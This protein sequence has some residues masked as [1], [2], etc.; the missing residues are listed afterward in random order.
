MIFEQLV[1]YVLPPLLGAF[2]GYLTN[3]IAIRMLFRPL[4]PWRIAGLRLPMT[5]GII[6]AKRHELA[7]K[8]GDMVGG[9]LFTAADV[10]HALAKESFR[11]ELKGVVADKLSEFLDRELGP[12]ESLIPI[13]YRGR[14]REICDLLR[15]KL[16]KGVFHYLDSAE[17]EKSLR[18]YLRRRGDE[19]LA[20]DLE[21]YLTPARYDKWR[22]HADDRIAGF[23]RSDGVARG[24]AAFVDNRAEQWLGSGKTLREILPADMVEILLAQL[25]KEIPPL[26]EKFGGMLY[27]PDFRERL[28]KKGREG[29]DHFLDSLGGLSGLLAGF[30]NLDKVYDRIPEFL[31]KA[32]DEIAR[33]LREEKTQ[34]Q[35][36]V[37]LRER[38]DG[39]LDRTLGSYLEK[40]PYEKVAGVRRF[41]RHRAVEMVRSRRAAD[42]VM[43]LAEQGVA[44]L[45]D[46]SFGSLLARAVP[47]GGIDQARENLANRLLAALRSPE[48]KEALEHIVAEKMDEW[49]YQHPLGKLSARI[50]G[51]AREELEEGI[52]LQLE[53]ILK[54]EVPPL[55]ETLNVRRMVEDKVNSLDILK[56]EGLLMGIMKEQFKYINLFGA[57]LGFLIGLTNLLVLSLR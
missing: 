46:R 38:I 41:V 1:P 16:V 8:M 25:E 43:G 49:L 13:A 3:Y 30:I 50:P 18:D 17:F 2:I 11:R 53:E 23:L 33:W 37:L 6:P 40:V 31:D 55:V 51:D 10:G 56:V 34:Q 35:V 27:D 29:I 12:V 15:W 28:V 54:K 4:L 57:L 32:G 20:R 24:V 44:H 52:C 9:H 36:G 45:K 21:S 14:F 22:A 48:A 26:L 7:E 5:P 39:L 19:L 47:P 42:T